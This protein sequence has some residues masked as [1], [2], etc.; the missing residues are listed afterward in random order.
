ME[1]AEETSEGPL[2]ERVEQ[3]DKPLHL[4]NT[5]EKTRTCADVDEPKDALE[6]SDVV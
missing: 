6:T 1:T 3:T 5:E 2:E 4:N